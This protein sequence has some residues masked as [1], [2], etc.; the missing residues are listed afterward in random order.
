MR[1]WEL[2]LANIIASVAVGVAASSRNGMIFPQ[3]WSDAAVQAARASATRASRSALD[4]QAR[5]STPISTNPRQ[6]P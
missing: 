2:A 1:Q 3:R 5:V 4:R 6:P